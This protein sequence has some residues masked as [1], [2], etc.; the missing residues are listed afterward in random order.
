MNLEVWEG[1][2]VW[3]DPEAQFLSLLFVLFL[4]LCWF[5]SQVHHFTY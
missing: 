3:L 5:L 1:D 4:S 2:Q